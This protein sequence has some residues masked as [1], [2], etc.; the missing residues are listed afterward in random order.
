MSATAS[1]A[2][3]LAFRVTP[4][5]LAALEDAELC[6]CVDLVVFEGVY[7]CRVCSTCFAIAVMLWDDTPRP[8]PWRRRSRR[9]RLS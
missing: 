4:Q 5:G 6:D 7:Q 2:S 8:L 1:V 3:D 9:R